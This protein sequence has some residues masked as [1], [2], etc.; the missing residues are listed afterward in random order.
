MIK[1]ISEIKKIAQEYVED[2][3]SDY[4]ICRNCM[5]FAKFTN[6]EEKVLI[7]IFGSDIKDCG[8]CANTAGVNNEPIIMHCETVQ[9]DANEVCGDNCFEWDECAFQDAVQA[10]YDA[11]EPDYWE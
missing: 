11:I 9:Y 1:S 5:H 7:P 3:E 8:V 2:N 6:K 4:A 10:R